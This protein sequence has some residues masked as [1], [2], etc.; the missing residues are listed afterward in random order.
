[1]NGRCEWQQPQDE[2]GGEEEELVQVEK[3]GLTTGVSKRNRSHT[4]TH[5]KNNTTKTTPLT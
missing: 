4:Q 5:D 3:R 1:V 2:T